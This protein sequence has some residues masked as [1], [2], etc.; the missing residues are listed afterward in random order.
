VMLRSD[1]Q[2][3]FTNL[4]RLIRRREETGSELAI[5]A[6]LVVIQPNL[7]QIAPFIRY[8]REKK[9][10]AQITA[11]WILSAEVDL[12]MAQAA[13]ADGYR[14]AEGAREDEVIGLGEYDWLLAM[15]NKVKPVQERFSKDDHQCDA[16]CQVPFER[17]FVD[18]DGICQVCCQ[19]WY[20]IGDLKKQSVHEVWNGEK[21][22]RFRERLKNGDY[23]D[24]GITCSFN[25]SP[26]KSRYALMRKVAFKA[27]RD[28]QLYLKKAR[29]K[30]KMKSD[31]KKIKDEQ[32]AGGVRP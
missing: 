29:E 23:R 17:I 1:H 3:V 28:P 4:E 27:I 32:A 8:C 13:I 22:N 31:F 9:I 19:S 25:P 12:K 6:S 18:Y 24:C 15:H 10:S 30:R 20:P 11:D 2:R 26:V 14:A 21:M 5:G 7:S 16:L